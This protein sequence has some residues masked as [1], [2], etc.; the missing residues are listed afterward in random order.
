M[1]FVTWGDTLWGM[2]CLTVGDSTEGQHMTDIV[3]LGGGSAGWLIAA[4]LAA[5]HEAAN[6]G[7]VRITLI[8]SPDVRTVGVSLETALTEKLKLGLAFEQAYSDWL[9]YD[10]RTRTT[11]MAATLSYTLAKGATV[12][13]EYSHL[14]RKETDETADF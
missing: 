13:L 14:V 11:S 2:G 4:V 9:Y 7:G 6:P 8:E 1:P 3:I 12:A 5:D 10:Y